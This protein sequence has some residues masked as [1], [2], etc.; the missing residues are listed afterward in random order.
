MGMVF[1]FLGKV[2]A[3]CS[4]RLKISAPFLSFQGLGTEIE[5]IMMKGGEKVDAKCEY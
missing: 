3:Y 4:V 2:F 5:V 1:Y